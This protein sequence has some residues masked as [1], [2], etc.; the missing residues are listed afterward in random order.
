[1]IL[2]FATVSIKNF[3][4]QFEKLLCRGRGRGWRRGRGEGGRVGKR[5]GTK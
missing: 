3:L 5:A 2:N 4:P 1:V